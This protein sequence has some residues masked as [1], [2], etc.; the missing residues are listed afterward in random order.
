MDEMPCKVKE[1]FKSSAFPLTEKKQPLPQFLSFNCG[2][3]DPPPP[4]RTKSLGLDDLD[5]HG[6]HSVKPNRPYHSNLLPGDNRR[7]GAGPSTG[8][9]DKES[10]GRLFICQT[11]PTEEAIM[12]L[13]MT[14]QLD[15]ANV[16]TVCWFLVTDA[17]HAENMIRR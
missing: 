7:L 15:Q 10:S 11:P 6:F 9:L 13:Q 8:I 4:N 5:D 16:S 1:Q 12:R 2:Y 14:I 3:F 17:P